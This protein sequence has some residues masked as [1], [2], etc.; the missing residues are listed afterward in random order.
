MLVVRRPIGDSRCNVEEDLEADLRRG[1]TTEWTA[2][3][4]R[5]N[6][7]DH[8]SGVSEVATPPC[9]GLGE[10]VLDE[11][12]SDVISHFVELLIDL[13]IVVVIVSAK[14]GD[15]GAVGQCDKLG[16]DFVHS[17]SGSCKNQKSIKR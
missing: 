2:E 5:T 17:S 12:H 11:A 6:L 9:I 3:F 7:G 4:H 1:Q 16:I 15:N 13:G 8:F 14:L 10:E